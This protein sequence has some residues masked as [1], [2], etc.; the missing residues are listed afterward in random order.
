MRTRLDGVPEIAPA[1]SAAARVGTWGVMLYRLLAD[2]VVLVHLGFIAFVAI[3]GMLAWRWP[4]L[5][6]LH[7]PAAGY[8]LA[9][10]TVGFTCPLTPLEKHLRHLAGQA[11]YPG[12]FV[13]HYLT[14]GRLPRPAD[15]AGPS[16][17]GRA[18]AP[19]WSLMI[20]SDARRS[21]SRHASSSPTP[22]ARSP[23]PSTLPSHTPRP[24]PYARR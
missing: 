9:I 11:G 16:S 17:G 18:T 10:V 22:N 3:G 14:G 5:V 1:D 15:R 19:P 21:R 4:R 24:S 12:G 23:S 8:A 20:P 2:A 6:W 13:D 7:L